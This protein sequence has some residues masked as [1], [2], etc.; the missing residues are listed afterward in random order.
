[1]K[2]KSD[3][4]PA[5]RPTNASA[6]SA[7]DDRR[8]FFTKLA[9]TAIGS[10]LGLVPLA[11]GLAVFLDPLRRRSTSQGLLRVASLDSVPD[12]GI[13]RQFPV[14]ADRTDAWN[15]Y[16]EEPIG[17]VYLRREPGSTVVQCF[18]AICPHAG[19]FVEF[20]IPNKQFQCPC[21]DSNFQPDGTRID[22]EHCPSPRDLDALQVDAA[23]L[24]EGEVWVEFKNYIAGSPEKKERG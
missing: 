3:R 2:K 21:H 11:S 1:M 20:N 13:A 14:V 9:A 15:R 10:L 8:G 4:D 7:A 22:P 5:S 19:C 16:P 12:D 18:N 6:P 23:K 17:A 24:A